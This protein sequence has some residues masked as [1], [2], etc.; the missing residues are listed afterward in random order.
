MSTALPPQAQIRITPRWPYLSLILSAAQQA[1]AYRG[2]IAL[3]TL[4]NGIWIVAVFYLWRSVYAGS[5]QVAGYDWEAMRTYLVLAY[6]V[7]A[8]LS[9]ASTARLYTLVRT[10]EIAQELLR[11]IDY[12]KA[13]LAIAL[14]S[15]LI[16][17]LMSAGLALV[18]A[19]PAIG[20][21]PPASIEAALLFLPSVALGFVIKFLISF[22]FAL[23]C[24]WTVNGAGLY[25]AHTAVTNLFSGALVPL[26]FF[27]D[28]LRAIAAWAPFQGII[29]TPLAIYQGQVSG[30]ELA[31]ALA[32]QLVWIMLLWGL[33]QVLWRPAIR[34]L[35]IQ[36]G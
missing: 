35:D 21:R 11:P 10:G 36:G 1:A 12:L 23:L 25:W 24:F 13:Q 16:E 6:S 22:M 17:G 30:W 28:W 8:L 3:S 4:G 7:N 33:A 34:S 14:G 2:R 15:A 26:A 5:S 9:F 19:I 29:A 31:S 32:L 18:I 20:I 27:P